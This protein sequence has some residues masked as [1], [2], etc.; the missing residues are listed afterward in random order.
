M[1]GG[2]TRRGLGVGFWLSI[3]WLVL[4]VLV[5][6]LAPWLPL[7]DPTENYLVRGERPP[8]SPSFTHWFG[9]DQDARDVFSRTAFGA[10]TSLTIGFVAI[11][12]GMVFGGVLG[13]LSGYFRGWT[14]RIASVVMLILLSFPSLI[15]AILITA[16]L[17][18]GLFTIAVTLG[19]LAIAPVGRLA[20]AATLTFAE[21]EFVTAAR[22]VGARHRR[23][24]VRELLPNVIIPMAA[25]SLL[26]MAIAIVAEGGLAFLGLSVD[27]GVTWGKL[28]LLGAGTRDLERAPWISFGPI[29]VLFVTVLALNY[30]GDRLRDYFDVKEISL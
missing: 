27:E 9:T 10:R 16:L 4:V 21:R 11:A 14:D 20:R 13:I 24:I 25:L 19:I 8:Y 23:I 30:A 5:A 29:G 22:A 1:S 6:V 15:L 7:K 2:S 3:T 12:F 28:I 17:D 26:G 18:R